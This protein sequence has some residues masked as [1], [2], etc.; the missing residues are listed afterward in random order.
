MKISKSTIHSGNVT[1]VCEYLYSEYGKSISEIVEKDIQSVCKLN[2]DFCLGATI[3]R[4][5]LV[6]QKKY[7]KNS[8]PTVIG[9]K[10]RFIVNPDHSDLFNE[11]I[12]VL[13][14]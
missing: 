1:V 4:D 10:F 3:C 5:D 12:L 8:W 2:D 11:D 6:E 13:L 14:R 9:K 7:T